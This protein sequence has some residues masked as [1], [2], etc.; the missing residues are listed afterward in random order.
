MNGGEKHE[1]KFFFYRCR[2]NFGSEQS[3]DD[4]FILLYPFL[5]EPAEALDS[6]ANVRV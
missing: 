3:V 1:K 4:R 5:I 2:K 6:S